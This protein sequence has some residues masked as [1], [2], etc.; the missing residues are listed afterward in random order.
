MESIKNQ[1]IIGGITLAEALEAIDALE[2]QRLQLLAR[3]DELIAADM[4][5]R[6]SVKNGAAK[7]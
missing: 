2:Q 5:K 4:D 6:R 1:F 3:A 7:N